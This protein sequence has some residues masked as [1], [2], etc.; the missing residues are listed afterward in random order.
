[1][2]IGFICDIKLAGISSLKCC[3]S[4]Y[5]RFTRNI[6]ALLFITLVLSVFIPSSTAAPDSPSI[7]WRK[8]YG[9]LQAIS[10][11]Q[12][13]DG[14]YALAGAA[15]AGQATLVKT[16]SLGDVQWQKELGDAVSLAQTSDS[17][18]VVFCENGDVVT[19]DAE[20]NILS[21][22]SLG[23][24][25]GVREGIITNDGTYIVVGNSI[26]EGQEN[27][28]W[29]RKVGAQGNIFWNM[30]FTGGFHVSAVV[31]TV[32]RGC[33]LAGNWKNNF[34]LARLDSNGNQQWS[35]NY[36]YGSPLDEHL[37][38]S[39]AKTKDGGFI[40]AG[41]GMW[42]SSNGM[43]PWLIKINSQ[44]YEQ[45]NLPY[46]QY[47][48]DSFCSVVQTADE[49]YLVA[50][51]RT[52][53]IM[54]A[55]SSGS[56]LNQ[57]QLGTSAIVSPLGYPASCLIP[58][59]DGGYV[60]AG[61]T[62]GSAFIVKFSSEANL[63]APVITI[64][65]PKS[66][67]Y[68]TSDIPLTFSVN[69]Q[70]SLFSYT[71]DG[72]QAVEITGNTTLN[73]LAVGAHNLT[74]YV[75]DSAGLV[76]T[77]QTI[78]FTIE[79]RFPSEIVLVGVAITVVASLSFLLYVKRRN[80]SDF[81]KNGIKSLLKKQTLGAITQNKMVWT[82]IIISLCFVLVFVQFFFPYVFYSSSSMRSNGS[83]EVGVTYVYERDNV[84]QIYS[85]VSRIKDLG[86][87]VIRVDLVCDPNIPSSYLNTVSDVFFSAIRQLDLKVALIIKEHSSP[88]EINYYLDRWGKDLVYV[89]IL[90][91]PDVASSWDMGALFTD[92]EAGS[93]FEEIYSIVEAHQL[94]VQ[95]FTNFSPAFIARTNL[96]IRFSEKL[97]FIGFDVF[98]D[99]LL[100]LSPNMI[101]FLHKITN[102]DVVI[103]EFGMSTNNDATQSDF[104]IRGLDLFKNMGLKGCW[105]VYWNSVDNDYGIR[106]RL[107]EQKVGEW[108]AQNA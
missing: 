79:A 60:I 49:G 53:S 19:T 76:G 20:G 2:L 39:I 95:R 11:I 8:T 15:P 3:R 17:G 74:V 82:L 25:G 26:R 93:K 105:L 101:Q 38:Y 94:A 104:I 83:F 62:S 24:N 40:L 7:E 67:K 86:F 61:S 73:G 66:E 84:D 48:S 75:R 70:N 55:D 69:Y 58:T 64:S 13:S 80:L 108:I 27:Y 72:Q 85:E 50:L 23:V 45:W 47:S 31:N 57:E 33:A 97:D 103:A 34:W 96:P 30:N 1:V 65:S 5:S 36:V 22:F 100:T 18:Y 41:T 12:T 68:E 102:R 9:G 107:T 14:G 44:G 91:E 37:V 51:S 98:M 46:S 43:I 52:G 35:Q 78:P 71:L 89:Q 4:A 29:L 63:Q 16:D 6:I 56:E 92:D 28:V 54:R 90:N 106:G 87:K 88:S 10:I 77:S 59:K 81:R 21:S 32:D 42:Q 99:S